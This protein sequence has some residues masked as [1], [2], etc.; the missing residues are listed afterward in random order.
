MTCKRT[1][2]RCRVHRCPAI[3]WFNPDN[4]L[5]PAHSDQQ[6]GPR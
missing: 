4:P 1:P 5:C 2:V 6:D 3:G